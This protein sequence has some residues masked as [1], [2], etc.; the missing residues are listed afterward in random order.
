MGYRSPDMYKVLT[1]FLYG[2][3][4]WMKREEGGIIE[5]RT[6][7]LARVLHVQSP[8]VR[9]IVRILEKAGYLS[10]VE[11]GVGYGRFHIVPIKRLCSHLGCVGGST[12]E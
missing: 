9:S 3:Y 1:M 4:D 12:I 2:D 5:F 7:A 6:Y 10:N 8:T 11:F